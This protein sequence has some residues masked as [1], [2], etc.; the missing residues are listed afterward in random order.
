MA[1]TTSAGAGVCF[2]PA[3]EARDEEGENEGT[4]KAGETPDPCGAD[5]GMEAN[6]G[7]RLRPRP[8]PAAVPARSEDGADTGRQWQLRCST[9]DRLTEGHLQRRKFHEFMIEV[10]AINL[11]NNMSTVTSCGSRYRISTYFQ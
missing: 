11:V 6:R 4:A 1:N 3:V 10:I 7:L 8:P 2:P 5:S 9:T